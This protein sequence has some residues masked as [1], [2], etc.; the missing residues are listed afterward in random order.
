MGLKRLAA[1]TQPAVTLEEAKTQIGLYGGDL[2]ELVTRLINAATESV[3]RYT[4]RAL[5]TQTWRLSLDEFPVGEIRVPRPPLGSI[6]SVAYTDENGTNQTLS[7]SLY[8]VTTDIE[9]AR[10]EPAYG[11][12]WPATR[13]QREAVR[14]TYTAGYGG[15]ATAVPEAI[16]HAILLTVAH[17]FNCRE[18]VASGSLAEVPLSV[19]W[20]LDGF[21]TGA[22]PE[23]YS[24]AK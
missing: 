10:I 17:W 13:C 8:V 11:E 18:P 5:V 4:G 20:L 3:E 16:R 24:L 6:S 12:V 7:D 14:V 9:P 2:D 21:K 19:V 23:W 15:D 1:A 22:G